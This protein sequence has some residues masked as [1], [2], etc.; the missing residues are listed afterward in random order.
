MV[1]I[2]GTHVEGMPW[3]GSPPGAPPS[4]RT[5]PCSRRGGWSARPRSRRR[6]PART[7]ARTA[8]AGRRPSAPVPRARAAAR[9]PRAPRAPTRRRRRTGG[10]CRAP[11]SEPARVAARRRSKVAVQSRDWASSTR[12]ASVADSSADQGRTS[13]SVGVQWAYAPAGTVIASHESRLPDQAEEA[14]AGEGSG[15]GSSAVGACIALARTERQCGEDRGDG[16]AG[17]PGAHAPPQ[18]AASEPS[19]RRQVGAERP[20]WS[21][22]AR[23][24]PS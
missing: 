4:A 2:R 17:A 22:D 8:P 19:N 24:H 15:V 18:E 5:R 14:V 10:P 21:G 20:S 3:S 11:A 12:A 16:H 6:S 9:R 13:V 23:R 7:R 1:R